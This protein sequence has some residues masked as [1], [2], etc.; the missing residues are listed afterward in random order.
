MLA[1]DASSEAK[2]IWGNRG[3]VLAALL[4]SA[5]GLDEGVTGGA[6]GGSP[7]GDEPAAALTAASAVDAGASAA[8]FRGAAANGSAGAAAGA[9][10][11]PAAGAADGAGPGATAGN[12]NNSRNGNS[13]T[14]G[15]GDVTA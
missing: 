9:A 10:S 5:T 3:V 7:V 6:A 11:D 1:G 13:N 14:P 4:L 15:T 12:G 2:L 8:D